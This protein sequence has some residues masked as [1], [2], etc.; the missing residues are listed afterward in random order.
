MPEK[1]TG[2]LIGEMHNAGVTY[3]ELA[4]EMGVTKPYVS[5]LLNSRRS[6]KGVQ[7]RMESA[8]SALL[9]KKNGESS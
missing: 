9:Q 1:W 7:E 5:M 3:Q 8:F 4:D 6:P 2:K